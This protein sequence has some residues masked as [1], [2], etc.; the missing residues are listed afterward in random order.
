MVCLSALA[1]ESPKKCVV[2]SFGLGADWSFDNAAERY[3]C[4]VHGFDPTGELWRAGMHGEA[5]SR[6]DYAEQY[7]SRLKHFHNWGLGAGDCVR[8]PPESIPQLWPGLG[9]PQLSRSNERE[10]EMRSVN[11]TMHD[12]GHRRDGERERERE[13]GVS[14]LKID[15]EGAEWDALNALVH[16]MTTSSSLSPS[17][18]SVVDKSRREREREKGVGVVVDIPPSSIRQLLV[19]W[20]W[21]PDSSLRNKRQYKLL[22]R[23]ES[24]G[25]R[26]WH[27][28]H[29]K[30]SDCCL[31]VS[32]VWVG[33][34]E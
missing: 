2:Y 27:I 33:E 25:Y 20:H 9:D 16:A 24:L 30:G 23:I 7:P 32:Y 29:H 18:S 22:K 21:D 11:R 26:P 6:I 8:Y 13:S 1:K 28:E 10:W 19:E 4:E 15:V 31:D 17:L 34:K 14:I 3:G 12:L 5:Y